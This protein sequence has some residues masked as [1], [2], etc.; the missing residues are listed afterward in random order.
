LAKDLPQNSERFGLESSAKMPKRKKVALKPQIPLDN[1]L[2]K[3]RRGRP[4]VRTSEIAGRS[5]HY[6][7]MF[8]QIWDAI[9]VP[10][11]QATTQE[12]VIAAFEEA[13]PYYVNGLRHL[14]PLTLRVLSDGRFPVRREAQIGFLADSLA[15][16]GRVSPRRSR[17]ICLEERAK[18]RKRSKHR[19]L[20][21][22]YYIECSCGY[23]G[24]A[25]NDAC[26]KCGAE[27]ARSL[28]M[29]TQWLR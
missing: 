21:R 25:R 9:G 19:I 5:Y 12:E 6:R 16:L 27:M 3:R 15:G 2:E 18:E 22:E 14:A 23:E 7:M 11:I 1:V 20:R 28:G 29:A 4:G 8:A 26:P 13:G 17:D 24:P 10:L